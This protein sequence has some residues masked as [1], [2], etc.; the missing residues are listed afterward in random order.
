MNSVVQGDVAPFRFLCKRD[1]KTFAVVG[2][3]VWKRN[4]VTKDEVAVVIEL[5]EMAAE[6]KGIL[7]PS[8][9]V[10]TL[11]YRDGVW[12]TTMSG[13][14]RGRERGRE[15]GRGGVGMEVS[16]GRGGEGRGREEV[17]LI[18]RE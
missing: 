11:V 13:G 8:S 1:H 7:P 14:R 2:A 17:R 10:D 5:E 12:G 15:R 16:E 4:D 9:P 18:Q 6:D 3:K